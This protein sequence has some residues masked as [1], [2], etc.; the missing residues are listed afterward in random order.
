MSDT[1]PATA[2]GAPEVQAGRAAVP[3]W[4]IF[5]LS[6]LLYWGMVY[7]DQNSGWFDPHVYSP[8]RSLEQLQAYQPVLG[9]EGVI[10]RGRAVFEVNCALCHNSDGAGK[11]GQAPSMV[12]SEW[13]LGSANRLIRIPQNGLSGPIP[14]K[15]EVW[16]QA[17][18]MAAMGA[19]LSDDDLAAVLSFIR[20]SWGNKAPPITPEQVRAV[21]AELGNRTQPWTASELNTVQ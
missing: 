3:V 11:P 2:Q 17:P 12:G 7:F 18:S 20:Q 14:L 15:G 1:G 5:L 21:R 16:S 13:V 8:Y 4:L 6:L 9:T 10:L 19:G